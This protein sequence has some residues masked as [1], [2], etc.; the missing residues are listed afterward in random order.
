MCPHDL[1]SQAQS[2]FV[3]THI[4][5]QGDLFVA[6]PYKVTCIQLISL[7]GDLFVADLSTG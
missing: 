4:S 1:F 7:Q 2:H 5:I 6:D 3:S